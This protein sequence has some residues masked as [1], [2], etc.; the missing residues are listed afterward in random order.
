MF[1]SGK[2]TTEIKRSVRIKAKP[3]KYDCP[4]NIITNGIKTALEIRQNELRKPKEKQT[5]EVSPFIST[6]NPKNPLVYNATR[7]S[8]EVL[9]RNNVPGFESISLINS[10]RQPPSLKKLLTKAEFSNE[11]VG[12]K[13]YQDLRIK[14]CE[15]FLLS[16]D[17]T[18]QNVNKTFALKT[19]LS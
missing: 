8:V 13:K 9:K 14:C 18:F 16:K 1:H 15:S 11:E 19:P 12:V 6:F 5:D 7:N 4:V 10:K 17:Y 2:L 3:K